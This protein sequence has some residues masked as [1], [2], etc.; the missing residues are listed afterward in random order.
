MVAVGLTTTV[1]AGAAG[2]VVDAKKAKPAAWATSVCT[3]ANT[4]VG[5]VESSSTSASSSAATAPKA[6]KK[7]LQSIV[8]KSIAATKKLIAKVKKAGTPDVPGGSDIIKIVLDEYKQVQRTFV[9]AQKQLKTAPTTDATA[10]SGVARATED[11]LES[12]LE[13][14]EQAMRLATNVDA[15]PLVDAFASEPACANVTA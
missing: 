12:G 1:A 6:A 8:A 10:L 5:T 4:W 9:A 3:A 11:A 15:G 2:A 14:V 7:K 13:H